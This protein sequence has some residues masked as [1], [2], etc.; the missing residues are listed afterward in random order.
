MKYRWFAI[1][2]VLSFLC[3]A[4][5]LPEDPAK[6]RAERAITAQGD[7][8][9]GAVAPWT[10]IDVM[11][12]E[13]IA[14]A[15]DEINEAGG[16]LGRKIRLIKRDDASS[17]EKGVAIAQEFGE[18]RDLVAVLGHYQSFVTIPASVVYQYYGLLLLSTVDTDP[19]LTRQ[20]FPLIFRT[21]P[22]DMDYGKKLAEFCRQRGF[23]ELLVFIERDEYGRD[24]SDAFAMVAQSADNAGLQILDSRS[25]N[26][27]T[28][29]DEFRNV[30]EFWKTHYSFDAMVLSG[31]LPQA[32]VII[33][34]ARRLGIQKPIIGGI[35]L[36]RKELLNQLGDQAKDVFL[37]TVYNSN[38]PSHEVRKFI[39]AFEQR[40][41]KAPDVEA[42]EGYDAVRCLAYAIRKAG[43]TS[44][45]A[46]AAAL[47]SAKNL[48]GVTG[49]LAFTPN[50]ARLVDKIY[51]KMVENGQ[52]R[53]LDSATDPRER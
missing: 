5:I 25:Y 8:V 42:A 3:G 2:M 16:L 12:W 17:V 49:E 33:R 11:L 27:G 10:R 23:K 39:Q 14:L 44:P 32:G 34:E 52:F 9:V 26:P 46:M 4:C 29:S 24:F 22:D 15:V 7:I 51:I 31:N 18:N 38:S 13:G 48:K 43:S 50:G 53:Y 20:G 19:N 28:G 6:E 37:S 41:G 36:D 1:L 40:Y 21:A 35:S 30:L 45:P 47:R